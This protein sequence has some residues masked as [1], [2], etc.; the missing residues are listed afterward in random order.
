MRLINLPCAG[1]LSCT[2]FGQPQLEEHEQTN[3]TKHPQA[4]HPNKH[5]E[6]H[7]QYQRHAAANTLSKR[8]SCGYL[9]RRS[10][11][12][13][14]LNLNDWTPSRRWIGS[15]LYTW[16][17]TK[18]RGPIKDTSNSTYTL[19]GW[20]LD[21]I[22]NCVI[23]L[24]IVHCEDCCFKC[25]NWSWDTKCDKTSKWRLLFLTH[26]I[27]VFVVHYQPFHMPLKI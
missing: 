16:V 18:T 1:G 6:S 27:L 17:S 12:T 4:S 2:Q 26:D 24:A 8:W 14:T 10:A 15:N 3:E 20:P 23:W 22:A 21:G 5:K 19:D 11:K 25:Q 7:A 9:E 13:L